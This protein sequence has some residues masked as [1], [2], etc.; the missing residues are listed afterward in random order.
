[1]KRSG[2]VQFILSE[3]YCIFKPSVSRVYVIVQEF[4]RLYFCFIIALDPIQLRARKRVICRETSLEKSISFLLSGS[5][6]VKKKKIHTLHKCFV[7]SLSVRLAY[8]L[9]KLAKI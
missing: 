5:P 6:L 4:A 2:T 8:G 1:M 7:I 3:K 9:L